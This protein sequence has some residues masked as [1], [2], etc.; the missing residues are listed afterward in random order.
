MTR[1][2]M[3]I[4]FGLLYLPP[5]KLT[6]KITNRAPKSC[7]AGIREDL[8][9][10]SLNCLSMEGIPAGTSP[11][12]AKPSSQQQIKRKITNTQV[13]LRNCKALNDEKHYL[14]VSVLIK[15]SQNTIL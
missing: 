8:A 7:E 15:F 6:N 9:L 10:V 14:N 2:P 1:D 11:L 13:L 3:A 5:M 4:T 12:M